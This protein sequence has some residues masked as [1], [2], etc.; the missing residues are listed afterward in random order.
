MVQEQSPSG[1]ASY[2]R[3]L[4]PSSMEEAARAQ[5]EFTKRFDDETRRKLKALK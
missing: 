4:E 3:P 2:F 5:R 1:R